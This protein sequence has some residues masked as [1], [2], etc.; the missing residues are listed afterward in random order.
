MCLLLNLKLISVSHHRV[1]G[2]FQA[3]EEVLTWRRRVVGGPR[4]R[5]WEWLV[6][7]YEPYLIRFCLHLATLSLF[8]LEFSEETDSMETHPYW[9]EVAQ[10]NALNYSHPQNRIACWVLQSLCDLAPP[11]MNEHLQEFLGHYFIE[12]W[13]QMLLCGPFS[14]S[15]Y[16]FLGLP[17]FATF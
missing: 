10:W 13:G 14:L 4:L 7:T 9:D 16:H 3:E 2:R 8:T 6:G 5:R 11:N 12:S 1:E 17:S 15:T